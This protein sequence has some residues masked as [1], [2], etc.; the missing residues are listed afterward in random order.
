M[1]RLL[2]R[3]S[4]VRLIRESTLALMVAPEEA[5][6]NLQTLAGEGFETKYGLYEAIDYTRSRLPRGKTHAVVQSY[7][8]H[9]QG[10]TFLSLSYLLLDQRMQQRLLEARRTFRADL[11]EEARGQIAFFDPAEYNA[12]GSSRVASICR[13]HAIMSSSEAPSPASPVHN[14]RFRATRKPAATVPS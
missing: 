2:F 9:H 12:A 8:A 5:C 4:P 6:L 3:F 10:M 14:T 11:P 1:T 13:S 7:M